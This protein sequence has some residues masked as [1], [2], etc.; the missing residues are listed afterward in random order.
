MDDR[1]ILFLDSGIGGLPYFQ[2]I[3]LENP[4]EWYVYTADKEN[5]PYGSKDKKT[6]IQLLE[7]LILKL[8]FSY[9]PKI[10]VIA[11]NT[12]SVSALD[13]L[14]KSFPKISFVGTVPAVKPAAME[15]R[16]G[17]IGVLGTQRTVEDPY[18]E[19]LLNES[20]KNAVIK[21]I[22]APELVD[23]VEHQYASASLDDRQKVVTK[24][25][26]EFRSAGADGIVLGCTHFLF[27]LNEFKKAASPDITIYD[28]IEGVGRQAASL[29][30]EQKLRTSEPNSE[31]N[32]LL[33]TGNDDNPVWKQRAEMYNMELVM[34]NNVQNE[35]G[36]S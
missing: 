18:I 3:S 30:N 9:D 33:V 16:S 21:K 23:F 34:L 14:R 6:L 26:S 32:I 19:I 20:G 25:V 24:Y 15:T 31:K 5:F 17:I 4:D 36:K 22:A 12:A 8:V 7:A 1:P 10:I 35:K 2:Y 28:S 29:L 27:L 13:A 11:C